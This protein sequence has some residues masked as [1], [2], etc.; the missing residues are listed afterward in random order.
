MQKKYFVDFCGMQMGRSICKSAE[1]A[2]ECIG[3]VAGNV[4]GLSA[5]F[6]GIWENLSKMSWEIVGK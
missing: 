2:E 4:G 3:R 6:W 1:D 5:D